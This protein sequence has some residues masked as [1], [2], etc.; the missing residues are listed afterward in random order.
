MTCLTDNELVQVVPA[1]I[2][3][4]QYTYKIYTS[5]DLDMPK[6]TNSMRLPCLHPW[7]QARGGSI[8]V[9]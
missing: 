9:M 7:M 6:Q 8:L 1:E 4:S 2:P 3:L 5:L